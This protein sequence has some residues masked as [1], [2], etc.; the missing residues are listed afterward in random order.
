MIVGDLDIER[1]A[2]EKAKAYAP[3][4]I[5]PDRMLAGAIA[6]QCFEPIRQVKFPIP[7]TLSP[8]AFTTPSTVVLPPG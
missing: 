3:L 2:V 4:I 6:L 5:D 8:D 7:T 1:V